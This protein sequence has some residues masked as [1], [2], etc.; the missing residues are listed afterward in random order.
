MRERLETWVECYRFN[1]QTVC[2]LLSVGFD[3]GAACIERIHA[4]FNL[5]TLALAG[6]LDVSHEWLDWWAHECRCGENPMEAGNAQEMRKIATI[7]DLIWVIEL[8]A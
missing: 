4:T 1:R 6:A 5:Y 8:T 2:L 7:D 3:P